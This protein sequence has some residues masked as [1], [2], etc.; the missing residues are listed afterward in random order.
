MIGT[1]HTSPIAPQGEWRLV[2]QQHGDPNPGEWVEVDHPAVV[3]AMGSAAPCRAGG[4]QYERVT[5]ARR[6]EETVSR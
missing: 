1:G 2:F 3:E 6:D 4:C 5:G